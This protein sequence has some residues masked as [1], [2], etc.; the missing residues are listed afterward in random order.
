MSSGGWCPGPD[1]GSLAE[2]YEA[3]PPPFAN[4]AAGASAIRI[5]GVACALRQLH[6]P[7]T[8]AG[9]QRQDESS[10]DFF[11][12]RHLPHTRARTTAV[13]PCPHPHAPVES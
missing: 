8:L 4:D 6:T 5:V 9:P 12:G 2:T 3:G 1:D 7:T 10:S 11:R 13:L